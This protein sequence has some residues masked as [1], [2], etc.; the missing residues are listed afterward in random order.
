MAFWQEADEE[1]LRVML[2]ML[3]YQDFLRLIS[4]L[5]KYAEKKKIRKG[6]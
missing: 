1:I 4:V 3:N 5:D 6:K 2:I